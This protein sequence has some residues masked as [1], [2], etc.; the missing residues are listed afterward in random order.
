[1][2]K[3]MTKTAA[4]EILNLWKDQTNYF[5]GSISQTDF[6]MMLQFRM[7]FGLAESITISAA[8]VLAGAKFAD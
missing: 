6:E 7:G 5:D 1:M 3:R 8:L 4:R 2:A